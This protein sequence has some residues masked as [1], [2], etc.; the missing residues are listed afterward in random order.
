MC[1]VLVGQTIQYTMTTNILT[2]VE[3]TIDTT[4]E[5]KKKKRK[6]NRFDYELRIFLQAQLNPQNPL[7]QP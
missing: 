4:I 2:K 7:F 5:V 6:S 3:G 1:W